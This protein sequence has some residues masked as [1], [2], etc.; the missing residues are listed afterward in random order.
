MAENNRPLM[1]KISNKA[2]ILKSLVTNGLTAELNIRVFNSFVKL[3]LNN[4]VNSAFA[5]KNLSE[6]KNSIHKTGHIMRFP[7]LP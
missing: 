3:Q 5:E 1:N 4:L 2:Q 6:G 7:I